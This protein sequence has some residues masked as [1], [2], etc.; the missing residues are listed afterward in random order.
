[1]HSYSGKASMSNILLSFINDLIMF[2]SQKFRE[3][4]VIGRTLQ[5]LNRDDLIRG[6]GMKVGPA[7][8]LSDAIR[9]EVQ[10][11]SRRSQSCHKCRS[12]SLRDEANFY[13]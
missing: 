13:V 8:A 10:N 4:R 1:M 2:R 6:L 5:Q 3:H 12:Q 11:S 9:Q 7:I